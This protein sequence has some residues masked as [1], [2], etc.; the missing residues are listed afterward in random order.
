MGAASSPFMTSAISQIFPDMKIPQGMMKNPAFG[1][2]RSG[3][4][5]TYTDPQTGQIIS[6][7]TNANTTQNQRTIMAVERVTPLIKEIAKKLGKF[8]TIHGKGKLGIQMLGNLFGGNNPLPNEYAE[9]QEALK[10][11]PES[12][13]KAYGLN[14]TNESLARMEDALKPRFGESDPGVEN[15][16]LKTLKEIAK[17]SAQ[18]QQAQASGYN[19]TP[20]QPQQQSQGL[21]GDD[22]DRLS[23][24]TGMSR[25]EIITKLR[26][27]RGR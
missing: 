27:A 16:L 10:L 8:Q 26:N 13:L 7:P 5:G 15:R 18:A 11:A 23:Q 6:T 21:S 20:G 17:N 22:I 9:G 19:V 3:A 25:E 24:E 1:S 14:P 12:L 2:Q 4:G